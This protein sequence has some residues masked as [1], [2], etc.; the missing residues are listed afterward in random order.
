MIIRFADGT[1]A[2]CVLVTGEHV[3]IN[4][5]YRDCL[6]FVFEDTSLDEIDE[7]FTEARC[8]KMVLINE[9]DKSEGIFEGYTIRHKLEK[10][11]PDV[12]E[13]AKIED[14]NAKQRV[15]CYMAQRTYS[16]SK[17]KEVSEDLLNTDLAIAEIYESMLGEEEFESAPT[18]TEE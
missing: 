15:M 4:S 13:D 18:E 3:Q 14:V 11:Y 10:R 5:V 7:L 16:E 1:E 6:G 2:T 9:E 8:E 17:L 12:E